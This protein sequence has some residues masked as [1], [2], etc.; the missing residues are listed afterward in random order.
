MEELFCHKISELSFAG[1]EQEASYAICSP[2]YKQNKRDVSVTIEAK[3]GNVI[4]T[5][6]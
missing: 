1:L 4:G 5:V 2:V 6:K 3:F